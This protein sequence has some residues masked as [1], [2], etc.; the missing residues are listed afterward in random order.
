MKNKVCFIS[1]Y[2]GEIPSFFGPFLNSCKWN[3]KFDFLLIHNKE[4][5]YPIPENVRAVRMSLD[6]FLKLLNETLNLQIQELPYYKLCD[7]RPAFGILFEEYIKSY[8]FWGICDTD[9]MFGCLKDFINDSLLNNYD[10]IYTMGH[11]S[12]IRN[13]PECNLLF[14]TDTQNS[15]NYIKVFKDPKNQIYDELNGFTE[16]FIDTKK[17]VYKKKKCADL[18]LFTNRITVST[19]LFF[20][21]IQPQN[22]F[23]NCCTDKNY[24]WQLFLLNHGKI[25]KVFFK[26]NSMFIKEYNYIHK[27]EYGLQFFV[28]ESTDLIITQSGYIKDD[29]IFKKINSNTLKKSDIKKYN[30]PSIVRELYQSMYWI[31]LLTYRMI[32][33]G[34]RKRI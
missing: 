9:L 33:N 18:G 16:K 10:K 22:R 14:K 25:K 34:I 17:R 19:K 1:V 24:R 8:D 29:E 15:Q 6:Y 30:K 26:R 4:I 13:V 11:L 31:L 12:L 7:F 23:K 20:S 32:K 3:P 2:F 27:L 21:L 28:D 5:P